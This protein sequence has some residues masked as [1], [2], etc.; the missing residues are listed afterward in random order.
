M[1]VTYD[2]KTRITVQTVV[3]G[4]A[5][6]DLSRSLPG[7]K[8]W[9]D[10]LLHIELTRANL[11]TLQKFVSAEQWPLD[12]RAAAERLQADHQKQL[13]DLQAARTADL[14]DHYSWGFKTKP[15]EHQ[16]RAFVA[17]RDAPHF[18]LFM[19]MGTGKSKV[20]C[21]TLAWNWSAGRISTALIIAPNGVHSRWL[22]EQIPAHMPDW[23]PIKT[24]ELFTSIRSSK[25]YWTQVQETLSWSGGLR[26][27]ALNTEALSH[28]NG[29]DV[30]NTVMT[31]GDTA[32]IVDESSRF[33]NASA[34]RTKNLLSL[35]DYAKL[36]RILTGTPITRGV[37]NLYSQLQFLA[38]DITG[39]RSWTSF[40]AQYC[41][42]GGYEG[43]EIVGYRGIDD[44]KEKM[45]PFIYHIKK[46][47]CLDLPP[48]VYI[49]R[50]FYLSDEAADHYTNLFDN[51][52]T[53]ID[54]A[55]VLTLSKIGPLIMKMRQILSG[56]LTDENG[57]VIWRDPKNAR[58]A[59]LADI[60][61][62]SG[63]QSVIIWCQFREDIRIIS[64]LLDKRNETFMVYYGG[65]SRKDRDLAQ[66]AFQEGTARVF[67][68]QTDTGGIGLNLQRGSLAVY[69]SHGGNAESRWQS[70]ARIDR[71]GQTAERVTY[72]DLIANGTID[73]NP[74]NNIRDRKAVAEMT[75]GEL[76]EFISATKPDTIRK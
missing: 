37:E 55:T 1:I 76:R 4:P 52:R 28:K 61:D 70:E 62:E 67:L 73:Q 49:Q 68:G 15:F 53:E 9:L 60:L 66:S 36:R 40:C 31:P 43:R 46:E 29:V 30:C 56:Y 47:D 64:E 39:H 38:E 57:V 24:V 25:K 58:L 18:G 48:K 42:F 74:L 45:R 44:L 33:G 19:D 3:R 2:G 27:F 34:S 51:L 26:V 22:T 10:P 14:G 12:L 8:R 35:R 65:V 5:I 32:L 13:D 41:I 75:L 71:I 7:R 20:I 54:G 72:I 23:V 6:H 11:E 50:K 59:E 16:L 63:D 69:F 17:S 21:D